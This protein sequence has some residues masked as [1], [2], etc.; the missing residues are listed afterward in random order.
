MTQFYIDK[1]SS[2]NEDFEA[3]QEKGS[4]SRTKKGHISSFI[5]FKRESIKAS[6]HHFH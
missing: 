2:F 6:F 1:V 4:L 5:P 3:T